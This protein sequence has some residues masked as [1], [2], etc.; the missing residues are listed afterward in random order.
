MGFR[1][2]GSSFYLGY[3]LLESSWAHHPDFPASIL[4]HTY[5]HGEFQSLP[6]SWVQERSSYCMADTRNEMQLLLVTLRL[7]FSPKFS[8]REPQL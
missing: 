5:G 1:E 3:I 6:L 8:N 4:A 7:M 2:L